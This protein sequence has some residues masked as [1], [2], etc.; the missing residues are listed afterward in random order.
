MSANVV[1]TDC[2]HADVEIEL[3]IFAAAGVSCELAACRTEEEVI[4]AGRGA[5][6]LLTQYAPVTRRVLEALPECRVVARYGVG[7]DTV[8]VAAA[9]ERGVDVLSVPDYCVDE[10]SD[11]AF[12]LVMALSRGIVAF[13]RAVHAGRWDYAAAGEL[14]RT[15]SRRLGVIGAGRTGRALA[16]KGAAVGS[17]SWF[18]TRTSMPSTACAWSR[19]TSCSR[20][21]TSSASTCRCRSRPAT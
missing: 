15:R 21:A 10:V 19:S 4:A 2:D 18:M 6:A 3:A 14:H 11:H 5:V 17:T 20:R 13:D 12:A 16:A 7:L 9:Q 1:I 8:D